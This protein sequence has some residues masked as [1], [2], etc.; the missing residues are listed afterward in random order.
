MLSLQVA[1]TIILGALA[2][3]GLSAAEPIEARDV[4]VP[5]VTYP[6]AGTVWY[7][8]QRHNVTWDN[9]NPPATISN[10][11]YIRLRADNY[12]TP[13]VLARD[14]D[15]RAGRVEV[16]VPPVITGDYSIVLFGDSG[17][18]GQDFQIIGVL[19]SY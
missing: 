14:F 12:E 16:T 15:L 9:S 10:R 6:H 18:W 8:G 3:S 11:A 19:D 2:A 5:R 7:S 1:S 4:Y 17:N 13:I